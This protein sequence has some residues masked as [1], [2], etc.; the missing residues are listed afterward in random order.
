M[1]TDYRVMVILRSV[2]CMILF[3]ND[4]SKEQVSCKT[5][6]KLKKNP[7]ASKER[8]YINTQA[9]DKAPLAACGAEKLRATMIA[10]HIR[11]K[12]LDASLE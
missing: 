2:D 5:C 12:D 6:L 8:A 1:E 10:D 7:A 11:L 3:D 9:R 4:V